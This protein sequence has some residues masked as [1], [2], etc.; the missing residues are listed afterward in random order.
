MKIGKGILLWAGVSLS[1]SAAIANDENP[2]NDSSLTDLS[3]LSAE[4]SPSVTQELSEL[5]EMA[6]ELR[7]SE[8][9]TRVNNVNKSG[10]SPERSRA[11]LGKFRIN[12]I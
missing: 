4:A 1:M 3:K 6:G 5:N 8:A 11:M 10:L 2:G 9:P 12:G 7:T